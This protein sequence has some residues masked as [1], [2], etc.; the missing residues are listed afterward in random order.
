[1]DLYCAP[2]A[3]SKSGNI[4]TCFN[5]S[6]LKLLANEFNKQSQKSNNNK[7]INLSQPKDGLVHELKT[8]YREICNENQFC[9]IDQHLSNSSKKEQLLQKF[10]PIKPLSWYKNKNTWLNTYDIQYVLEQYQVLHKNFKFLGV[11]P[12]D[13]ESRNSSN[14]CIG[15]DFCDFTVAKLKSLKKQR[16]AAV[17][18]TD[19]SYKS[20]Q[21]WIS[22][23]CNVN[24]KKTNYGIYFYDSVANNAP[25]EIKKFAQRIV[26]EMNDPLFKYHENIVQRQRSSYDCGVFSIV[27]ISQCLKDI[28]FNKICNEMKGDDYV[29]SLRNVLYRPN[30]QATS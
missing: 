24:P 7:I 17:F 6:E 3:F 8:A 1:M 23:Y 2:I 28:E 20:G 4:N 18:N 11:Q 26:K 21:H 15:D 5:H 10:R 30:L 22:L 19:P 14:N 13:F 12:I 16:F 27:F 29:N 25:K 9:W